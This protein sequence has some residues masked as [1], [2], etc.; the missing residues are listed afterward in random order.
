MIQVQS[1]EFVSDHGSSLFLNDAGSTTQ[2]LLSPCTAVKHVALASTGLC[3]GWFV[4]TLLQAARLFPL[5][6]A[7]LSEWHMSQH[8]F[9]NGL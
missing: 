7:M 8:T 6:S 1:N 5:N 3:D 2:C 4:R 9:M